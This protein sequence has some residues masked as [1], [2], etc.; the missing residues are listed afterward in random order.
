MLIYGCDFGHYKSSPIQREAF[1]F[2]MK[3]QYIN[4]R[5]TCF[6]MIYLLSKS[7]VYVCTRITID[8]VILN[9]N[10]SNTIEI[11]PQCLD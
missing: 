3:N 2:S 11:H 6:A 4:L 10:Q 5:P 9:H 8:L 1:P 7:R